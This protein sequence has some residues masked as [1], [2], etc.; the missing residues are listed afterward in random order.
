[1]ISEYKD[2]LAALEHYKIHYRDNEYV[3]LEAIEQAIS[4][5]KLRIQQ[6]EQQGSN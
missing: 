3:S 5:L 1:M 2:L 6:L 4:R